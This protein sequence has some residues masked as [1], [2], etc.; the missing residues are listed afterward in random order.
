MTGPARVIRGRTRALPSRPP[1]ITAHDDPA[2]S[3]DRTGKNSLTEGTEV[4]ANCSV[5]LRIL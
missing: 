2:R 3:G 4:T 5:D 1:L